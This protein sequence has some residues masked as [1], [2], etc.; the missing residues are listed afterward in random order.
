MVIRR[1]KPETGSPTR[2][3]SSRSKLPSAART[4]AIPKRRPGEDVFD[5]AVRLGDWI[6]EDE[7][8]DLPADGAANHDH[9]IYGAPKQY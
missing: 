8:K 6:P 4:S 2:R 5:Y 7:R 1:T 3:S 9:Y